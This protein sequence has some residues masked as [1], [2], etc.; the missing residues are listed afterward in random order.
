MSTLSFVN[1]GFQEVPF[2]NM[3]IYIKY[4]NY[5]RFELVSE[6]TYHTH[7]ICPD[8]ELYISNN[9][10][11]TA[12]NPLSQDY[13]EFVDLNP[14]SQNYPNDFIPQYMIN[15][16]DYAL[17]PKSAMKKN[18][19]RGSLLYC[20]SGGF[21]I[22]MGRI[23]LINPIDLAK[24]Y[25]DNVDLGMCLDIPEYDEGDP[26]TDDLVMD[27]AYCQKRNT[28]YILKYLKP[29]VELINI[30]HGGTLDQK[31]KYLN[32]IHDDKVQRLALP[33]VKIPMSLPRLNL[34]FEVL[35]Q[36]KKLGHY[37]HLHLLGSFN[38]GV[39]FVLAKLAHCN[40]PEVEGINFTT[41]ASSAL[42]N[43]V[44]LTWSKTINI[45][46]GFDEFSPLPKERYTQIDYHRSKYENGFGKFNQYAELACN[47]LVCRALKYSYILRNLRAGY[48]RNLIFLNHNAR[49]TFNYVAMVDKFAENLTTDEYIQHVKRIQDDDGSD[50]VNC[51]KFIKRIEEVGLDKAREEFGDLIKDPA[52]VRGLRSNLLTMA[53][54][55]SNSA[56]NKIEEHIRGIVK[57]YKETDFE[58]YTGKVK[59]SKGM[60]SSS[61][62]TA[63]D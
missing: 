36:A 13:D 19:D 61:N 15:Y 56:K 53:S 44:N 41:D 52:E 34:I 38:K 43:A 50:T 46:E 48:L 32:Y 57:L 20:D 16:T 12:I 8:R 30:I 58:N 22:A 11:K 54:Q 51:L 35:K 33:S 63:K 26:F 31:L 37:K 28:D 17:E 21:Q 1:A 6:S 4:G 24:F 29:E 5:N 42:Q 7:L 45:W 18:R 59:V 40:I 27:L 49:E 3:G 23:G 25:N 14:L 39:L 55:E 60:R 9:T 47:C 10:L 2:A 62:L